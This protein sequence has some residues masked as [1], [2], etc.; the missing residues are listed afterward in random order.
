[1]LEYLKLLQYPI[2]LPN[3]MF[4][5]FQIFK[6]KTHHELRYRGRVE[7][8]TYEILLFIDHFDTVIMFI[9][10]SSDFGHAFAIR[11]QGQFYAMEAVDTFEGW[12]VF[13][14][15]RWQNMKRER[16]VIPKLN[17]WCFK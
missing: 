9:A 15:K 6:S 13:Q 14:M 7:A 12:R 17:Q 16:D 10:L 5:S 8:R 2:D 4:F 11:M 1:M 3:I